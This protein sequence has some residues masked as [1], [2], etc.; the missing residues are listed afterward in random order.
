MSAETLYAWDSDVHYDLDPRLI[1]DY[2]LA[3]DDERKEPDVTQMK[4]HKL[5]YFAQAN[6]LAGTGK[7]LF[8]S[9]VHAFEHGPIIDKIR[10][11]FKKFGRQIIVAAD[12]AVAFNAKLDSPSLPD[13]VKAFLDAIWDMFGD[14][15]ATQLRNLSHQDAPWS[16]NYVKGGYKIKISDQEMQY[17]YR[18][19]GS[20][21]RQVYPPNVYLFTEADAIAFDMDFTDEDIDAILADL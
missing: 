15:S 9:D 14:L 18:Q 6:Y 12:D 16:D 1:C 2:F 7:R 19:P 5:M 10:D 3:L 20:R 11:E 4:L 21:D 17:W 8:N 13:S